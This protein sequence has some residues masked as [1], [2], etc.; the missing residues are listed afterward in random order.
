MPVESL[1]TYSFSSTASNSHSHSFTATALSCGVPTVQLSPG[2]RTTTPWRRGSKKRTR[3][4]GRFMCA[5]MYRLSSREKYMKLAIGIDVVAPRSRAYSET[6]CSCISAI[7]VSLASW[8]G[9][10]AYPA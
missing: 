2:V 10:P 7:S 5:F 6:F 8:S 9:S 1:G 3:S 4:L